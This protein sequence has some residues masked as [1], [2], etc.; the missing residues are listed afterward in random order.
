MD[1][2][3]ERLVVSVRADT[4]AFAA[5]VA[6]MRGELEGP[7]GAGADRAGRAIESALTRAARSG[8][9][10]FDDLRRVALSTLSEI[11]SAAI[12]SG[13]GALFGGG[14][15]GGLLATG[16][17]LVTAALGLPGRATGGPVS[18]GRAY[19]VGE[20]GPELFV[21]TTSGRVET[22][23]ARQ[24]RDVRVSIT[25]NAPAGSAPEALGRS[26]RQVARAVRAALDAAER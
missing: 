24:G 8:K 16:T 11:A 20:R 21:P 18:P 12:S 13:A 17:R 3:I 10:G 25:L 7:L 6:A 2:E 4:N 14:G 19:V 15:A 5:D 26:S 9:L 22:G 23:A 1:E